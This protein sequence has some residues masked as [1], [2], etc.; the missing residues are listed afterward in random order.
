MKRC[1][2]LRVLPLTKNSLTNQEKKKAERVA[3]VIKRQIAVS[4]MSLL[5]TKILQPQRDD[6]SA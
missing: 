1:N 6:S 4:D 3:N 5:E 2:I